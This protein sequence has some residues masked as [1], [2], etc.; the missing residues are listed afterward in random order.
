MMAELLIL[1]I[2]T[3]TQTPHG[4]LSCELSHDILSA[5]IMSYELICMWSDK[6]ARNNS[7]RWRL[8]RE[9]T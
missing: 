7:L 3:Q 9:H 8:S 4:P 5:I 2:Y 6:L 1:R